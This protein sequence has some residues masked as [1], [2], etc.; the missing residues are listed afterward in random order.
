MTSPGLPTSSYRRRR[1]S[2]CFGGVVKLVC[3]SA[4]F[5][6]CLSF[7][8][9]SPLV[10]TISIDAPTIFEISLSLVTK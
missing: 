8:L 9:L 3:D 10:D 4:P 1:E 6:T 5:L 2:S 7:P